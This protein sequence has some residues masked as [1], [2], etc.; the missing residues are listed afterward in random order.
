MFATRHPV[1]TS[2]IVLGALFLGNASIDYSRAWP[3]VWPL[4]GGALAVVLASRRHAVPWREGIGL[5]AKAGLVGLLVLLVVGVPLVS[6]YAGP[7][8]ERRVQDVGGTVPLG[9]GFLLAA[10]VMLALGALNTVAATLGAVLALPLVRA[11][12]AT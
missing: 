10:V 8:I 9:G 6:L 4:L 12:G 7:A 11:R 2:G 1:L 5:G 3:M